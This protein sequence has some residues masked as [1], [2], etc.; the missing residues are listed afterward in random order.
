M[1]L[2]IKGAFDSV[3]WKRLLAHLWSICFRDKVFNCFNHVVQ[4]N[5]NFMHACGYTRARIHFT[6]VKVLMWSVSS[7]LH[8]DL[9]CALVRLNSCGTL[10][11]HRMSKLVMSA[12]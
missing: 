5:L 6:R 9:S 11:M 3:W 10:E 7:L 8:V 1:A 4:L 12:R 2:D